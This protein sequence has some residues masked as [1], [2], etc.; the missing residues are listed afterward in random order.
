METIAAH[1]IE[2]ELAVA[3]PRRAPLPWRTQT[4]V[5]LASIVSVLLVV[6]GARAVLEAGRLAMA[7]V[8]GRPVVAHVTAIDY[9]PAPQGQP[10]QPVGVHF[11]YTDPW[12]GRRIVHDAPFAAPPEDP[13]TQPLPSSKPSAGSAVHVGD[14]LPLRIVGRA[15]HEH[16]Y[17]WTASPWGKAGFLSLCGLA[18]M[19]VGVRLMMILYRW[20]G[21]RARLLR[22]GSAVVGTVV[23]KR[24]DLGDVARYYVRFGYA[25][26]PA[27]DPR[28][29]EEQVS[30]EQ[31]K[32]YDVGQPVT[33]LYDPDSP[34]RAC[35]Y[36]LI[37]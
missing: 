12:T 28:E 25:T 2:P 7:A 30:L 9:A 23:Y 21:L 13:Q 34:D 18:V 27:L 31:W 33:V 11:A 37:R 14:T 6:G 26:V 20:Q 4:L 24:S 8:D 17:L 22:Y 10:A 32:Q 29:Q 15:H 36:A 35:L 1:E 5:V 3:P 19:A 16:A